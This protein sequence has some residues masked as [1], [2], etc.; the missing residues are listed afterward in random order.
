MRD[1]LPLSLPAP[2]LIIN[3]DRS[4][5][6]LAQMRAQTD[7]L[8]LS[9]ERFPAVDGTNIPTDL[10]PYFCDASGRI[11]SPLGPGEIG[12]YASHL[13][14]WRHL[15]AS[16]MPAAL[17][18]EDDAVLPDD[19]AEIVRDLLAALPVGWDMVHLCKATDRGFSTLASLGAGR[20]LIRFSRVPTTTVACLI[21]RAGAAKML[22]PVCPRMWCVDQ[23]L[24]W[25]WRFGL[26]IYGIDPPPIMPRV[27]Q[28]TIGRGS[29]S[30][31]RRGLRVTPFRTP[32]SF[33]F[34]LRK[35]GP[36][37]WVRCFAVNCVV[38][39]QA[40]L[41]PVRRSLA[42]C[43]TSLFGIRGRARSGSSSPSP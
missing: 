39:L 16:A 4:T 35:L 17:V 25:P 18:C 41:I 14:L 30:G 31:L 12:C 11:V 24:R 38:K 2:I 22:N 5:D 43:G 29:R 37:G 27:G 42:G 20:S 6:R 13:A 33:L 10:A 23:D 15:V 19:L 1:D 7:G 9:F 34:N 36:L 8:G 21:S 28:S 26:D 32:A 40:S 3:L